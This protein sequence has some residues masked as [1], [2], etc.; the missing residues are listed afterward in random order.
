MSFL[1]CKYK[2]NA[3]TIGF[4]ML[5]IYFWNNRSLSFNGKTSLFGSVFIF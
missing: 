4:A 5:L 1:S 2:L 3:F